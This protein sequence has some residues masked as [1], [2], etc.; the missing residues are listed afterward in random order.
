[1]DGFQPGAFQVDG[2]QM[3]IPTPTG[4]VI[5]LWRFA[6]QSNDDDVLLITLHCNLALVTW[7]VER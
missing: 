5:P 7:C 3:V 6:Q 2:F 1:M 4:T